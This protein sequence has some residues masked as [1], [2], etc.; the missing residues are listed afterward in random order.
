MSWRW[1]D[2]C[3]PRTTVKNIFLYCTGDLAGL[4]VIVGYSIF[5]KADHPH[6]CTRLSIKQFQLT[7]TERA[8]HINNYTIMYDVA[9]GA[10]YAVLYTVLVAFTILSIITSSGGTYP[11][12]Q[13]LGCVMVPVADSEEDVQKEMKSADFFLAARNSASA[14]YVNHSIVEDIAEYCMTCRLTTD[15]SIS[16]CHIYFE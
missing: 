5:E 4:Q 3:W 11:L 6:R 8:V 2:E 1:T 9:V 7:F 16:L 10:A 15:A 14:R 12:L 13:K